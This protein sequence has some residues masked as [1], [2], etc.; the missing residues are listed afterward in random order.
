MGQH[1]T[2]ESH[3]LVNSNEG[4]ENEVDNGVV[5]N[6]FGSW[7]FGRAGWCAGQDVKQWTYDITDWTDNGTNNTNHLV[8][9]GYYNGADYVPSDG[10]GNGG[11]NIR[12]VVWIVF[13]GPTT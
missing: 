9:R 3:P 7:P 1:H 4:C 12:A 2:Y 8:Y 5:A 11:L 13:Y 6:Q 10:I